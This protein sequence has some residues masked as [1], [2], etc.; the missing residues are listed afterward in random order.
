MDED[1]KRLSRDDLNEV[2]QSIPQTEKHLIGGDF[3]GHIGKRGAAYEKV[4]GGF[5]YGDR[6]SVGVSILYFVVAYE[7][8]IVN[9][10]FKKKGRAF[11]DF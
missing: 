3:N 7:L 8:T 6:N 5:D 1:V 4:H 10:Y 2:I 11:G 9:F